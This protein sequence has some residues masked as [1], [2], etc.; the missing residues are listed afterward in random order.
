MSHF[1]CYF[2]FYL[3]FSVFIFL[4]LNWNFIF[5]LS[6][7]IFL[8]RLL[9]LIFSS[10]LVSYNHTH[11]HTHNHNHTH[12]NLFNALS[13]IPTNGQMEDVESLLALDK[14]IMMVVNQHTNVSTT[15]R[16]TDGMDVFFFK[17]HR[18]F[19]Y[20]PNYYFTIIIVWKIS[21]VITSHNYSHCLLIFLQ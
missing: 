14:L 17:T 19:R 1:H 21:F 2:V 18:L 6:C 8:F 11:I 4:F 15:A 7:S 9:H 10:P 13:A 12:I 5:L 16:T 3:W 20:L